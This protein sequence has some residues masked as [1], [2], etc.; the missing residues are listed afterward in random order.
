MAEL[1][2]QAL[3]HLVGKQAGNTFGNSF[4]YIEGYAEK[5]KLT[6]HTAC[7][8]VMSQTEK[9]LKLILKKA[10]QSSESMPHALGSSNEGLITVGGEM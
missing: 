7:L 2:A 6:P 8:K 1:S 10:H 3:C 9:V 5:A 4:R